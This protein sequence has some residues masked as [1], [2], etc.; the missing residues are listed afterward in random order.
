MYTLRA[1]LTDRLADLSPGGLEPEDGGA[2][3]GGADLEDSVEVVEAAADVGH[4]RPL[5]QG[6]R[7]AR[8][9]RRGHHLEH[10][11]RRHLGEY[12]GSLLQ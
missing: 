9:L 4:G 8:N 7:A 2:G 10:H 3:E 12:S 11:Q 1:A 5:L 6:R